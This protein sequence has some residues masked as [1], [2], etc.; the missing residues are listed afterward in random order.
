[1]VE[2]SFISHRTSSDEN[3]SSNYPRIKLMRK[4]AHN[5]LQVKKKTFYTIFFAT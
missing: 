5:S 4:Y 2:S 1:M 3:I